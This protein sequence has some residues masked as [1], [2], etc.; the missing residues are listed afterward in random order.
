MSGSRFD[1]DWSPEVLEEEL[2]AE[3]TW[4]YG[5]AVPYSITLKRQR[6]NYTAED[7]EEFGAFIHE[8]DWNHPDYAV[9]SE[10][11]IYVWFVSGPSGSSQSSSSSDLEAAKRH[12]KTYGRVELRWR[13]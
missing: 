11:N 10:G 8:I 1:D 12:V 7:L 13:R 2:L 3:G 5:G 9:N 4:W 6:L